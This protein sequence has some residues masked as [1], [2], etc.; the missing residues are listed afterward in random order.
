MRQYQVFIGLLACTFFIACSQEPSTPESQS[1]SEKSAEIQQP[2][3]TGP[4]EKIVDAA[5]KSAMI[6]SLEA[7][8]AELEA[9]REA[10][11][12]EMAKFSEQTS[13]LQNQQNQQAQGIPGIDFQGA[14]FLDNFNLDALNL[15]ALDDLIA[16]AMDGDIAG[17]I[18]AIMDI[19]DDLA[20]NLAD[21]EDKIADI[22]D[23]IA[24]LI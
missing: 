13:I 10:I 4:S 5:E 8:K 24:D 12:A 7:E 9:E 1:V 6:Q 18:D 15:P 23:Q 21:I 16:A 20:A 19:V 14:Q 3:S 22:Q 11:V 2:Q 17:V